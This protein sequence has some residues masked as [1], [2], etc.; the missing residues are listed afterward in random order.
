MNCELFSLVPTEDP[1]TVF[2]W[3][4]EFSAEDGA[5]VKRVAMVHIGDPFDS[6]TSVGY[7][8]SAEAA[9]ARWSTVVPLDVFWESGGRPIAYS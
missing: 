6:G 8:A 1:N 2:A 7:H 4:M 9:C 5:E 3:G